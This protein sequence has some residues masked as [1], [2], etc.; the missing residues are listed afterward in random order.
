MIIIGI[1]RE[2]KERERNKTPEKQMVHMCWL[3]PSSNWQLP[4]DSPNLYTGH[5]LLEYAMSLWAVWVSCPALLPPELLVYLLTGMS[6]FGVSTTKQ[7]LQQ[8]C[9]SSV[10]IVSPKHS[11]VPAARRKI[12][13]SPA[14]TRAVML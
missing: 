4:V 3:R 14:E 10:L 13:S 12:N 7:H 8:P 11:S 1:K 2:R 6:Q 9:V 5:D